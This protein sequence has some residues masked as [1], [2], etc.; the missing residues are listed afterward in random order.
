MRIE[1]PRTPAILSGTFR[2]FATIVFRGFPKNPTC[3]FRSRAPY[4]RFRGGG[5]LILRGWCND[6][7]DSVRGC[8]SGGF[9]SALD[10]GRLREG[11]GAE[12]GARRKAPR[13]PVDRIQGRL[14]VGPR[15]PAGRL[16]VRCQSGRTGSRQQDARPRN[17]YLRLE[18]E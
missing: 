13:N 14:R 2:L 17:G 11:A 1:S 9:G 16:V 4:E 10:V 5:A 8:R 15:G 18:G 7:A 6:Q 12:R 3:S